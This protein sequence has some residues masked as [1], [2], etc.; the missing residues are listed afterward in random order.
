VLRY[1]AAAVPRPAVKSALG[2]LGET[3]DELRFDVLPQ[4]ARC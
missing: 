4:L 2:G 1:A 3:D